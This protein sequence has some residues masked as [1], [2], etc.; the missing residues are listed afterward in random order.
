MLARF[1]PSRLRPSASNPS[2]APAFA[3]L[4]FTMAL[5]G[6]NATVAKLMLGVYGPL[7]LTWMRWVVVLTITAPFAWHE[8]HALRAAL[9]THWRALL[10]LALIG[11]MLQNSLVF[12]GLNQ[13]TA[14]HLGLLNSAIPVLLVVLRLG[15]DARSRSIFPA[16]FDCDGG[17]SGVG[18]R[19]RG[20]GRC[21]NSVSRPGF[22]CVG[23]ATASSCGKDVQSRVRG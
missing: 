6:S 14:M 8:R 2:R 17:V 10:L 20:S 23:A 22:G 5:W 13:S 19:F 18:C 16:H 15:A 1:L 7:T 3:A 4:I 12:Y 21:G 11:G 9:T